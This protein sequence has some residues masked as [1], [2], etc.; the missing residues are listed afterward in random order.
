MK[1]ILTNWNF[2]RAVRLIL[3]VIIIVQGIE[4]KEWMY[5]IAGIL[6]SGMAVANIGCCGVGGCQVPS[7]NEN[8]TSTHKDITY[9]EIH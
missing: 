5:A 3:G 1:N 9:E 8:V 2:M 4:A 7:R 6:L